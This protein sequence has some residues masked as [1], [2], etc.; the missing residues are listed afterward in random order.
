MTA[1]GDRQ[2]G[3]LLAVTGENPM[4]IDTQRKEVIRTNPLCAV[5]GI[6][7][8]ATGDRQRGD[9]LAATGENLALRQIR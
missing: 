4:T 8:T 2:R 3:H 5:W 1:T 9:L 6:L 7:M